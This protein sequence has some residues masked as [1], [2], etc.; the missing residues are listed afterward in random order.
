[1]LRN[2]SALNNGNRSA[3]I[4]CFEAE[5]SYNVNNKFSLFKI[6]M[7]TLCNIAPPKVY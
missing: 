5:K 2:C 6:Y 7:S 3:F 1:M 4:E